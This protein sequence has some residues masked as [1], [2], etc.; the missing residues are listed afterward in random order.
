VRKD[1]AN[2]GAKPKEAI[3]MVQDLDTSLTRLQATR[4]LQRSLIPNF[5]PLLKQKPA[6]TQ[7]TTTKRS[8]IA[9]IQ[10]YRWHTVYEGALNELRRL[11]TGTCN[12]TGK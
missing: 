1:R 8:G 4:H 6:A 5:A 2:D 9:A 10:Q 12:L 3:D 7:A 11:N